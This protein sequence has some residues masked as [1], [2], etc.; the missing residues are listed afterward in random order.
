MAT[1]TKINDIASQ[2]STA[3]RLVVSTDFFW[4]YTASGLQVKIPAEFVRAY[5]SEGI[6][7]TI[8]SDGNWVIGG[9]STGVKAEGVTP[10]FRGGNE[11]IEV[12]YDN[13]STWSV[14][15]LYT[16]MSPVISD[17]IEAYENI[18]NS[19]QGRVT[20]ENGRVT[21]ENSRVKAETSRV[22]AEKARVAAE[23]QRESDFAT[24]KAAADKATAD[25]NGVAQHPPYVDA[26]GYFYRWDTT[27]KAYSKTDVNLTGKAF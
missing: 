10:K 4:V 19:E 20:A 24:S 2:L 22:D 26:D 7:P 27:T 17:L 6:K 18:V 23:T 3:S 11:G 1:E 15:A 9:E 25:A 5:L 16:S 8:N 14:L 13:G 21:A 12:S